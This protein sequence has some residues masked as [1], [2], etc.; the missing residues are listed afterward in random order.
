MR[1]DIAREQ[2]KSNPSKARISQKDL[3]EL[4]RRKRG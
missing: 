2:G 3:D 1:K 4:A